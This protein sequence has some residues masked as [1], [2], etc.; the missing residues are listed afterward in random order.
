MDVCCAPEFWRGSVAAGTIHHIAWRTPDDAAQLRWC[1]RLVALGLN[2]TPVIDRTYFHSIYF[3]E[4]GGVLFE[5]ATR[6]PSFTVDESGDALSTA[7]KLLPIRPWQQH[8]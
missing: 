7:L 2:G 4:L 1:E 3:R 8:D 5:R 6:L